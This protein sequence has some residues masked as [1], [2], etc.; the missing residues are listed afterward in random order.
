[1]LITTIAKSAPE[2]LLINKGQFEEHFYSDLEYLL[3]KVKSVNNTTS[4]DVYAYVVYFNQPEVKETQLGK[5]VGV[6]SLSVPEKQIEN[7]DLL[8]D[9]LFENVKSSI[10]DAR[11]ISLESFLNL[12]TNMLE[13][14]AHE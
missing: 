4:R 2:F 12:H 3:Y 1:M 8:F 11:R 6:V 14:C 5:T 9:S 10:S 7:L 13:E